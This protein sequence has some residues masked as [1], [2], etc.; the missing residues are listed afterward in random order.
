[1][2]LVLE[3]EKLTARLILGAIIIISLI[4]ATFAFFYWKNKI[5]EFDTQKTA[6]LQLTSELNEQ[7]TLVTKLE[8]DLDA[9]ESQLSIANAAVSQLQEKNKKVETALAHCQ[10]T[11]S[12]Q[13]NTIKIYKD[14][15]YLT[16]GR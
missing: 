1:M 7:K 15:Y 13:K 8:T 2:I 9:K 6:L 14:Y 12:R 10:D 4:G 5:T 11:I 3:P 16:T